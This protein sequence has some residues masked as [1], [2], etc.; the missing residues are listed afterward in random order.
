[1]DKTYCV[2]KVIGATF[3][4]IAVTTDEKSAVN[5]ATIADKETQ[6]TVLIE[7]WDTGV[8]NGGDVKGMDYK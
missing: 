2:F 1:M 5:L 3:H 6:Y 8:L 4:L 7:V